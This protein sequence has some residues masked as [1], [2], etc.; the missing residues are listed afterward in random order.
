MRPI[1]AGFLVQA[2]AKWTPVRRQEH[3][4]LNESR[5][6]SD[7]NRTEHASES[8]Y[9]GLATVAITSLTTFG[10]MGTSGWITLAL[11]GAFIGAYWFIYGEQ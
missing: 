1:D 11:S 3:E 2:P 10:T 5:A 8:K 6:C 7:S 9:L 4:P